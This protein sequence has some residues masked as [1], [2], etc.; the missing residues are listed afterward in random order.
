[1]N[2]YMNHY[3][4]N[5][6]LTASKEQILIMLYD[7]AIR[8][9]R[10][11]KQAIADGRRADKLYAINKALAIV[12]E[13]SNTLDYEVGGE[14]ALDLSR[15]YDFSIR[16]LVAANTRNDVKRLETV[17]KILLDLREGFAGAIEANQR[18]NAVQ[19][20]A[21]SGQGTENRTAVAG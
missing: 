17:E 16:E 9:V 12:T 8:F 18:G 5:S 21:A 2:A 1:M 11:A 4:N 10:Q 19:Q 7:G 6:I 20:Q 15:L 13:F 3:Q 14:I